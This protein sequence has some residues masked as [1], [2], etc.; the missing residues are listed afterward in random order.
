MD[1]GSAVSRAMNIPDED[2]LD[3]REYR[4]SD[5]FTRL[6]KLAIELAEAMTQTPADV[7]DRLRDELLGYLSRGQLA[8]LASSIAWENHRARLNRALGVREAGFSDGA[9][10]VLPERP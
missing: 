8:E 5:R 1:I 2:L 10:C 7:P 9:V 4:T 6:E 3:L